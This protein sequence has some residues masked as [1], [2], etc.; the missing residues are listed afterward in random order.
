MKY[1]LS[2]ALSMYFSDLYEEIND[3]AENEELVENE[4]L[5]EKI[6][7]AKALC[8]EY[9]VSMT[10][11][12]LNGH[13]DDYYSRRAKNIKSNLDYF[14]T[15]IESN[16][17]KDYDVE[18]LLDAYCQVMNLNDEAKDIMAEKYTKRFGRDIKEDR[19]TYRNNSW[20]INWEV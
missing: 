5:I 18:E 9:V 13:I 20:H 17:I 1:Y 4:E 8:R 16:E 3:V 12:E 15:I 7:A 6:E 14:N 10:M 11:D 2:D 19:I